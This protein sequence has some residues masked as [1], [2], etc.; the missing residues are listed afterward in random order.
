[1]KCELIPVTRDNL[2]VL[3]KLAA[4]PYFGISR[5]VGWLRRLLFNDEI[6][7]M[8]DD[9]V[10]G[11]ML[12]A[13]DGEYVGML[14]YYPVYVY[15]R[16]KRMLAYSGAIMGVKRRYCEWLGELTSA[17]VKA[18]GGAFMFGNTGANIRSIKV[19][20]AL[21]SSVTGPKEGEYSYKYVGLSFLTLAL[22]LRAGIRNKK[23][24]GI[25]WQ[26][27]SPWRKTA[28]MFMSLVLGRKSKWHYE[29]ETCFAEEKFRKFWDRLLKGN[30]GVMSS[31][32]PAILR[33]YFN[34][35]IAAG[36]VVLISAQDSNNDIQ[37]YILLRKYRMY[38]LDTMY[39]YKIIDACAVN[40]DVCCL[41]LLVKKAVAYATANNGGKIEF[42]GAN[43]NMEKWL[44]PSLWSR[45]P[46]GHPTFTYHCPESDSELRNMLESRKG[47][48]FGPYDGERCLG[49]GEY[50]DL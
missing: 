24:L 8:R 38:G 48:F 39:K 49:H 50:I 46:L 31:R 44:M 47:W 19:T 45:R 27:F 28:A 26:C 37:G 29:I 9:P 34:E 3:A 43:P 41:D 22:T 14:C 15:I 25:I 21:M 20:C 42:I 11:Y 10:R 7:E 16:Q 2:D 36:T 33:H 12:Q 40:N 4:D 17:V 32:D 1:M 6:E 23:V 13:E 5:S 35:S 30:D 18:E